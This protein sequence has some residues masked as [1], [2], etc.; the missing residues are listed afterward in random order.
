LYG[1]IFAA[2]YLELESSAEVGAGTLGLA[3]DVPR[4]AVRLPDVLVASRWRDL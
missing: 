3:H 1:W 2:E 4:I